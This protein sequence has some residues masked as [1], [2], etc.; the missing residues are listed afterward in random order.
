MILVCSFANMIRRMFE[1]FKAIAVHYESGTT[2]SVSILTPAERWRPQ[3]GLGSE[4]NLP[5][6]ERTAA[7]A[8]VR[9]RVTSRISVLIA[10]CWGAGNLTPGYPWGCKYQVTRRNTKEDNILMACFGGIDNPTR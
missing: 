7:V 5:N 8:L 1:A 10:K 6:L 4:R 2:T 3:P 9:S